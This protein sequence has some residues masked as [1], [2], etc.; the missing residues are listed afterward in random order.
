MVARHPISQAKLNYDPLHY[1][2]ILSKNARHDEV[3]INDWAKRNL[4]AIGE[5][6]KNE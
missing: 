4:M 6:Y 1:K 2:E 5:V 3:D